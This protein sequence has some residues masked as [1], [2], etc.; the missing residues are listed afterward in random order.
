MRSKDAIRKSKES[1]LILTANGSIVTTEAATLYV[2]DLDTFITF[3]LLEDSLAVLSVGKLCE[4]HV[5]SNEWMERPSPAL[6]KHSKIAKCKS[7]I[8]CQESFPEF[9]SRQVTRSDAEAAS[10][11]REQDIPDWLQPFADG[12]AEGAIWF[13]QQCWW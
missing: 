2:R 12:L 11:D 10:G 4:E 8:V 9:L 6:T 3:Q 7:E 13:I 5:S 1:C